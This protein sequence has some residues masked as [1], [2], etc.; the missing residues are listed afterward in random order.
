MR[1]QI[2]LLPVF[3]ASVLVEMMEP[4]GS[5]TISVMSGEGESLSAQLAHE[6]MA[7]QADLLKNEI[8]DPSLMSSS[9][10]QSSSSE[11]EKDSKVSE[12]EYMATPVFHGLFFLP[13]SYTVSGVG[14]SSDKSQ[15][16]RALLVESK[17]QE[18]ISLD[19]EISF[20][21]AIIEER[22]QGIQEVQQQIGEVNEIF[23]DL[24]V[25]VHEQGAMIDDIGSNIEHSHEATAQAKSELVKA[26]KTQ[27]SSSSLAI[28][29]LRRCC[30]FQTAN[31]GFDGSLIYSKWLEQDNL[32]LG[33]DAAKVKRRL[34]N[35]GAY[36]AKTGTYVDMVKAGIIDPVKVVRTACWC[37]P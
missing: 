9:L 2:S 27:R 16:Q 8:S 4:D 3:S 31:A 19:N 24:A 26:S 1:K 18:V 21:E 29:T 37:K 17:R 33:F 5:S 6:V 36:S 28:K 32:N 20:N 7:I 22:E 25:L 35:Y 14:V 15:E 30:C 34:F 23:K 11:L 12:R 13:C 10:S